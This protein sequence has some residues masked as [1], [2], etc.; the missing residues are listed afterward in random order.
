[1]ENPNQIVPKERLWEKVWGQSDQSEYNNV[2]VYLSFLRKKL[3]HLH[4][5]VQIKATRSVGYGLTGGEL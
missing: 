5:D 3:K 2:E 1:M 4:S